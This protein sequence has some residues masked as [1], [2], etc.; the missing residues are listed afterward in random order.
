MHS[1][2]DAFS[3]IGVPVR[4]KRRHCLRHQESSPKW[5]TLQWSGFPGR[6]KGRCF[7]KLSSPWHSSSR[8]ELRSM[9]AQS[10]SSLLCQEAFMNGNVDVDRVISLHRRLMIQSRGP[11]A[12]PVSP[13]LRQ[14]RRCS[15]QVTGFL[16]GQVWAQMPLRY[17]S[18]L[19]PNF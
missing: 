3:S 7:P 5:P 11:W 12:G 19:V 6:A 17:S 9:E 14:P 10:P 1:T 15:R 2:L 13:S 18:M 16:K 8:R 4:E